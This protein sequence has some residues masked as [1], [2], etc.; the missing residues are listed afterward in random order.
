VALRMSP[1]ANWRRDQTPELLERDRVVESCDVDDL[2]H[3]NKPGVSIRRR[4]VVDRRAASVPHDD[5]G[6]V[7]AVD[8]ADG[9]RSERVSGRERLPNG[10]SL[11]KG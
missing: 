8:A 7:L 11:L 1:S 6:V 10:A 3:L 4:R 5:N 9:R 2:A